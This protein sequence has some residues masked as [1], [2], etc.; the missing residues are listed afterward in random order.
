MIREVER[1][2]E[3]LKERKVS[4]DIKV[5]RKIAFKYGLN[6]GGEEMV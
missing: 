6:K 2:E 3:E 4:D 1:V 5:I